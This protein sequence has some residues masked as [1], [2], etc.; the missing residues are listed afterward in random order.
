MLLS[1][2]ALVS[3]LAMA[4]R[5]QKDCGRR[6]IESPVF[7]APFLCLAG[8]V[9]IIP[10]A[11]VSEKEFGTAVYEI[12][13]AASLASALSYI[14][15]WDHLAIALSRGEQTTL[16]RLGVYTITLLLSFMPPLGL[17]WF[18]LIRRRRQR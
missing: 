16:G 17:M 4:A 7:I 15:V 13:K 3:W 12:A 5:S 8:Y 1:Y 2:G 10:L 18:Y 14:L 9:V 11:P 6:W